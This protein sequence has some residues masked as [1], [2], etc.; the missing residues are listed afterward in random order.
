MQ[1][2]VP[3]VRADC[4]SPRCSRQ[5]AG[6]ACTIGAPGLPRRRRGRTD[7]P[8]SL[9][10]NRG[11]GPEPRV[12]VASLRTATTGFPPTGHGVRDSGPSETSDTVGGRLSW[13]CRRGYR[14]KYW[15]GRE[16]QRFAAGRG[17]VS[18]LLRVRV[19]PERG[20]CEVHWKRRLDQDTV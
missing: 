13:T 19:L 4:M 8:G 17:S 6:E 20:P 14:E 18:S 15:T 16:V 7:R 10:L 11:T 3:T 2:A 9:S 1:L 5:P 12:P